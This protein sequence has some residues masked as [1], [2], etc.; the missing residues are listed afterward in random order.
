MHSGKIV[1]AQFMEHLPLHGF[2]RCVRRY[3]GHYKVKSF[4]CLDQFL[5]WSSPGFVDCQRLARRGGYAPL[6]VDR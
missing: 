1:F 6:V 2:R 4:T 5:S 3:R